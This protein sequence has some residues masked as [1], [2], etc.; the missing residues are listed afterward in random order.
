M[1]DSEINE[2][3][4][5]EF[6]FD[7][8]NFKKYNRGKTSKFIALQNGWHQDLNV[9]DWPVTTKY[10]YTVL[11]G[12]RGI[13]GDSGVGP[14]S[15]L[16]T[17]GVGLTLV[18][19]A[20]YV[21]LR[22]VDCRSSLVTLCKEGFIFLERKKERKTDREKIDPVCP[23]QAGEAFS[24]IKNEIPR[25]VLVRRAIKPT[26]AQLWVERYGEPNVGVQLVYADDKFSQQEAIDPHS[27]KSFVQYFT[28]WM[29]NREKWAAADQKK[30]D[31]K[32]AERIKASE[33]TQWKA[34]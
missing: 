15:V 4:S 32:Q 9:R 30:K 33:D 12:L 23:P 6:F 3:L 29:E 2:I 13:R 27:Q 1:T 19:C 34:Y 17:S 18:R 31:T 11:L 10:L 28:N 5:G 20:S 24:F 21:G 14:A 22:V 8:K 26:T 16:G 25:T 7:V